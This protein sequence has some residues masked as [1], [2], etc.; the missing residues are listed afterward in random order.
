MEEA[1]YES[2][3]GQILSATFMDYAM[4][5][6]GDLPWLDIRFVEIPTDANPIGAKGS[7]QAGAI[8]APQAVI[9][10]VVDALRPFGVEH[11]DMPATAERVWR[12]M[13][14]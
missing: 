8:A 5:R 12:A 7:G 14:G 2:D 11:I 9:N 10:A 3:G 1:L 6:G 13:R 4:P